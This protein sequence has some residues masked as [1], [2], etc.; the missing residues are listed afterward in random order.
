MLYEVITVL[1]SKKTFATTYG[2]SAEYWEH[3]APDER[4]EVLG[5]LKTN[6]TDLATHFHACYQDP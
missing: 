4:P 6:L 2:L 3:F 1:D 5:F